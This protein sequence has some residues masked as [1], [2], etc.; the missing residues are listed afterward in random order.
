MSLHKIFSLH[1]YIHLTVQPS[2]REILQMDVY[3]IQPTSEPRWKYAVKVDAV[4]L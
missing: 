1:P 4:V 3:S 2:L